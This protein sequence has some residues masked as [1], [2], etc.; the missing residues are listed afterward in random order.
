MEGAGATGDVE[1]GALGVVVV[2]EDRTCTGFGGRGLAE[3]VVAVGLF[4]GPGAVVLGC[5]DRQGGVGVP[6]GAAG[7]RAVL[8]RGDL[9]AGRVVVVGVVG[10]RDGGGGDLSGQVVGE[11][12]GAGLCLVA[13]RV[14]LVCGGGG[15]GGGGGELVGVVVGVAG[16]RGAEG[17]GQAVA[18]LVV[19]VGRGA[20]G[21]AAGDPGLGVAAGGEAARGVVGLVVAAGADSGPGY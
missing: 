19:G 14:V 21:G 7:D 10:V 20:G 4:D 16:G 9:I 1:R 2:V 6:L 18:D 12:V 3:G 11:G 17:G 15:P 8:E 5:E 13:F